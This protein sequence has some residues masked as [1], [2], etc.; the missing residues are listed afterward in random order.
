[1]NIIFAPHIDDELIGCFSK[2]KDID[3]VVYFF[4]VNDERLK[5]AYQ[6]QKKYNYNIKVH[7]PNYD[8]LS[9]YDHP[10]NTIYIPSSKDLHIHHKEVNRLV[11][12]N[13]TKANRK[14]YSIDMNRKPKLVNNMEHKKELMYDI[15]KSQ[16]GLFNSDE[17]YFLFEDIYDDDSDKSIWVTFQKKGIHSFSR[18]SESEYEDVNYLSHPHRHLFK[19]KVTIEVNHSDREIEFHQFLNWLESKYDNNVLNLNNKSCEMIADDLS[20]EISKVYN[21]R[22]LKIEVSEDGECGCEC[23]Y[24]I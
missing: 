11:R 23:V 17:K 14:F 19:F 21:S 18:A 4:D 6:L 13:F 12:N 1:M 20:L 16:H 10:M 7:N 24:N 2:L 5:E 8:V 9:V 3:L 22:L 15:Y